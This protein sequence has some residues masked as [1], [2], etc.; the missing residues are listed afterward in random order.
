VQLQSIRLIKVI[1][2]IFLIFFCGKFFFLP[3]SFIIVF[4]NLNVTLKIKYYYRFV[5]IVCSGFFLRKYL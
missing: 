4:Y 1:A 3:L 5:F 2:I